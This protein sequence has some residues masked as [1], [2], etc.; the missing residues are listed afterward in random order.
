MLEGIELKKTLKSKKALSPV[1]AAIILIAV[2]VAVSIAVAAW[3]GSLTFTFM[4]T[5]ELKITSIEFTSASALNDTITVNVLNTGTS[6]ISIVAAVSVSG[7]NVTGGTT[8]AATVG[9]GDTAIFVVAFT[10][11]EEWCEGRTY[12]VE[13][14]SSKGNKFTYTDTAP[15]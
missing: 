4:E 8:T 5:E 6:D 13:L 7:L 1:V 2:T 3:M 11:P 12:N 9:K 15:A 14:L 10:S